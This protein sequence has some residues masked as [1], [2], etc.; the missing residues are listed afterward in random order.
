MSFLWHWVRWF[1]NNMKSK[2]LHASLLMVARL[3]GYEERVRNCKRDCAVRGA[4][5]HDAGHR[6]MDYTRLMT[7]R[8]LGEGAFGKVYVHVPR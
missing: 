6:K 7:R 2:A 4:V 5:L 3:G 8:Q 1:H